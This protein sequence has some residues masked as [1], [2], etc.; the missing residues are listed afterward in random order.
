MKL[1]NRTIS[2]NIKDASGEFF[3]VAGQSDDIESY[4]MHIRT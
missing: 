4:R 3:K 1:G 2:I